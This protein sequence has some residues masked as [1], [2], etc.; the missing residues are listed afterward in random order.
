MFK[1]V[2][3]MFLAFTLSGCFGN[4][5]GYVKGENRIYNHKNEK[6]HQKQHE[7]AM[8]DMKSLEKN[9]LK[10]PLNRPPLADAPKLPY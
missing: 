3:F 8:K 5:E 10:D 1:I 7:K 2:T 9:K 4:P 6:T